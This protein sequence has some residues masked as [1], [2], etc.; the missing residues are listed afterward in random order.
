MGS[1]PVNGSPQTPAPAGA[2]KATIFAQPAPLTAQGRVAKVKEL[3]S[4]DEKGGIIFKSNRDLIVTLAQ[5]GF[6]PDTIM[7]SID[8][9]EGG[10]AALLA[11]LNKPPLSLN[12]PEIRDSLAATISK[13]LKDPIRLA[14]IKSN[15][16]F[17]VLSWAKMGSSEL[18]ELLNA[19]RTGIMSSIPEIKVKQ[20]GPVFGE[21]TGNVSNDRISW[22]DF[23]KER[24]PEALVIAGALVVESA[25][26]PEALRE[27]LNVLASDKLMLID[28]T[29]M[30]YGIK[31]AIFRF[32][33]KNIEAQY[34]RPLNETEP[35]R[36][37]RQ[38]EID[39]FKGNVHSHIYGGG[40]T[41]IIDK[42]ILGNNKDGKL[43]A[44][45]KKGEEEPFDYLKGWEKTDWGRYLERVLILSGMI[46][47]DPKVQGRQIVSPK[48]DDSK[49]LYMTQFAVMHRFITELEEK[50]GLFK[51]GPN[52]HKIMQALC[53]TAGEKWTGIPPY[54]PTNPSSPRAIEFKAAFYKGV[55]TPTLEK[56]LQMLSDVHYQ[57]AI[58][59]EVDRADN[60]GN[61]A[62]YGPPAGL[63]IEV[64]APAVDQV[65]APVAKPIAGPKQAPK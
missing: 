46:K 12:E 34:P 9:M 35:E 36:A 10:V 42:L 27:L 39:K 31:E 22:D 44:D 55:K 33:V 30:V 13:Q 29:D 16:K 41:D 58:I 51:I 52:N 8:T 19:K 45:K 61:A 15:E 53:A 26:S 54:L 37:K 63:K 49:A 6:N 25:D 18:Q 7:A 38:A 60:P 56:W 2:T 14:E 64:K 11:K 48:A 65:P 62:P 57:Q 20:W 17:N 43:L 1:L 4:Q 59:E 28:K 3:L 40:K 32:A 23:I 50:D 21:N 47:N 5:K 24:L